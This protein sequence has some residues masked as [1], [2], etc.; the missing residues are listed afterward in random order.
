M[1]TFP[2]NRL[3]VNSPSEARTSHAIAGVPGMKADATSDPA[4]L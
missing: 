1:R 2:S 4:G 3:T